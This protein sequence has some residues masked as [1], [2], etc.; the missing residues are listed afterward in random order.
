MLIPPDVNLISRM[1]GTVRHQNLRTCMSF[2]I[3]T[4][5]HRGIKPSQMHAM[6]TV[7]N[8]KLLSALTNRSLR[9][10]VDM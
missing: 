9:Y 3:I 7:R 10:L 5:P 4:F 6:T 1:V 8:Y 2:L